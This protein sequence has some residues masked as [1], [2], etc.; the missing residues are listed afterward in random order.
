MPELPEVQTIVDDLNASVTNQ[1]IL[2]CKVNR[3]SII[4]SD[5]KA[6]KSLIK[7]KKINRVKRVGKYL[8]FSLNGGLWM[9]VHLRM[10]GK[11]IYSSQPERSASH[12]RVVFNLANG[13]K[14]I[15]HDVRCFGTIELIHDIDHHP[16][17]QKL[18]W[19][20]WDKQLTAQN[21]MLKT[22]GRQVAIKTIL[23][24]Q[25]VIAGLGNIY[26]SEIL[27]DAGIN[28]NA[29]VRTLKLSQL[30]RMIVSMRKVLSLALK[31]NGTSI[32]DFRRVDDKQGS[33]QNFLK[34]Y[35]KQGKPCVRCSSPIEKQ[36]IS[37]RSTFLCPECQN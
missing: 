35:G 10:T 14:L 33:F 29:R 16:K 9:L 24:D 6:F 27:F 21:L 23:L 1:V 26:A 18:G 2:S 11:F 20:P 13:R 22:K 19:D 4:H 25:E 34:V 7:G 32:S 17:L 37:Q 3:P 5:I 12:E 15:Y 36:I 28:P 30:V 8:V 31:H